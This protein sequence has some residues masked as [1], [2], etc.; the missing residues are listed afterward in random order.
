MDKALEYEIDSVLL[1]NAKDCKICRVCICQQAVLYKKAAIVFEGGGGR[2]FF[3]LLV[4]KYVALLLCNYYS[5]IN[6]HFWNEI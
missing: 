4:I 1:D 2:T 6:Y 3:S 5:L